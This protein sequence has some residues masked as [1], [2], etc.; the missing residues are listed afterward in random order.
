MADIAAAQTKKLRVFVSYS[1]RDMA[2]ADGLV[3]E[4]EKQNV[5]VSID[6]RDLP[7]GEEWQKELADFI[8]MSDTVLWLVSPDSVDSKWVNWELGEVG[9]SSKRLI[10]IRIREINPASLPESLGKIHLLPADCLFD[11]DRHLKV[12][13]EVLNTDAAWL[14]EATRLADRARQWNLKERDKGL[15]LRGRALAEAETWSRSKPRSAVTVSGEILDLI[16]NS[17][18]ATVRRQRQFVFAALTIAAVGIGLAI[19][20][21]RQRNTA[22]INQSTYLAKNSQDE[23]TKGDAGTGLLL[24]ISALPEWPPLDRPLVPDATRALYDAFFSIREARLLAGHTEDVNTVRFSSDDGRILTSSDDGTARIWSAATGAPLRTLGPHKGKVES[25][26]FSPD[27][28]LIATITDDNNIYIWDSAGEL[29]DSLSGHTDKVTSAAFGAV[30]GM[31]ISA[32]RDKTARVWRLGSSDSTVVLRGHE[33]AVNSA[34][35]SP[36][37]KRAVTSSKDK[38]AIVWNV[39]SGQAEVRLIGHGESVRGAIFDST[40]SKVAT[41]SD[42]R[43]ARVWDAASGQLLA[44]LGGDSGSTINSIAFCPLGDC[45]LTGG[46]DGIARI[47][48]VQSGELRSE[49]KGHTHSITKVSTDS[50]GKLA[51]TAAR[52]GLVHVWDMEADRPEDK[53][54]RTLGGHTGDILDMAFSHNYEFLVTAS[55]DRKA[56]IWR[57]PAASTTAS[58][59]NLNTAFRSIDLSRD[60]K[61]VALGTSDGYVRLLE[62]GLLKQI[63]EVQLGKEEVSLLVFDRAGLRLLAGT[64]L[65]TIAVYSVP[66]LALVFRGSTDGSEVGAGAFDEFGPGFTA[67][68]VRGTKAVFD[69]KELHLSKDYSSVPGAPLSV[70]AFSPGLDRIIIGE[71][72]SG[73]AR[74]ADAQTGQLLVELKGHTGGVAHAVFDSAARKVVTASG[75]AT[76]RVWDTGSGST[77][78]VLRGHKFGITFVAISDDG[79]HV[80]TASTDRTVRLWK[81]GEAAAVAVYKGHLASVEVVRFTHDG[82]SMISAS[83]DGEVH[84]WS[85]E[86]NYSTMLELAKS[87]V[88]RCLTQLQLESFGVALTPP[89][90]CEKTGL[91]VDSAARASAPPDPASGARK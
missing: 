21:W 89:S 30:A 14:K 51:V 2:A 57:V 15:L 5:E 62:P 69:G 81:L 19:F 83:H 50:R 6:R 42:D 87:A 27:N 86:D 7:Y 49:L 37:S 29:R 68:T 43:T 20:S 73:T 12:L 38:S 58:R 35:F 66:S 80:A 60:G 88:P 13:V 61:F 16:M 33:G 76:A 52:D 82:S 23:T 74:I 56:R 4:L 8:R 67:A 17:R 32:S 46:S 34:S 28:Q 75:D 72:S 9:R 54:L 90:W 10:P 24:A 70:T 22:L 41:F 59:T 84:Q 53:K 91:A 47:W 40:G 31:L 11:I 45:L 55:K 78:Q 3:A 79:K 25:A 36:N 18:R 48:N 44:N 85:F 39:E 65:G 77:L 26:E 1:R 64:A 63:S 71:W